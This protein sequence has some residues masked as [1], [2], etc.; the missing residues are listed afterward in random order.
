MFIMVLVPKP[1]ATSLFFLSFP[2]LPHRLL[3]SALT[4]GPWLTLSTA[5]SVT[6]SNVDLH[7][8]CY[9]RCIFPFIVSNSGY[10]VAIRFSW[11]W[12]HRSARGWCVS[13]GQGPAG[14]PLERSE[15]ETPLSGPVLCPILCPWSWPGLPWFVTLP[16]N[17]TAEQTIPHPNLR[18]LFLPAVPRM[19]AMVR[20]DLSRGCFLPPEFLG[21]SPAFLCFQVFAMKRRVSVMC[22]QK[23][24]HRTGSSRRLCL[25]R[26]TTPVTH[27]ACT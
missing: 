14:K 25:T 23:E 8:I 11:A 21:T 12:T 15:L 17:S 10:S 6:V 19:H 9:D 18:P 3:V 16:G 24:C 22:L 1:V 20:P 27:V 13:S 26:R 5:P 2:F 7:L 4:C